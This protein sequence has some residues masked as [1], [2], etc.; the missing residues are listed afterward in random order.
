MTIIRHKLITTRDGGAAC[1]C[2][3]DPRIVLE[4][5]FDW[6]DA[7]RAVVAHV[8]RSRRWKYLGAETHYGYW[9]HVWENELSKRRYAWPV[10]HYRATLAGD[11][12]TY[13]VYQW[14]AA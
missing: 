1:N 5:N 14:W 11:P 4:E 2:G 10:E 12:A 13:V 3:Y 9:Y 8:K 7:A 6:T